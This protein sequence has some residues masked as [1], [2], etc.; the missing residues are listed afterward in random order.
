[1]RGAL[2][3]AVAATVILLASA[4]LVA[5]SDPAQ[6]TVS[7][8]AASRPATSVGGTPRPSVTGAPSSSAAVPAL[9]ESALPALAGYTYARGAGVPE[10]IRGLDRDFVSGYIGRAVRRGGTDAGV[11]QVVRLRRV[12][13]STSGFVD[14]FVQQYAQTTSFRSERL[15]GQRVRTTSRFRGRPGGLVTWFRGRDLVLVYNAAGVTAARRV[16][17]AYL[18]TA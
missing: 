3:A 8:A 10:T 7:P 17:R 6:D 13:P 14:G 18:S 11:V 2:R 9:P 16:A 1:M 12:T 5:C 15:A 4:G